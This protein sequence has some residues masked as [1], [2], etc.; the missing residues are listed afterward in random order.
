MGGFENGFR[1]F[2]ISR[3]VHG[4]RGFLFFPIAVAMLSVRSESVVNIDFS[5]L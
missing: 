5:T 4:H 3:F 2:F 1:V